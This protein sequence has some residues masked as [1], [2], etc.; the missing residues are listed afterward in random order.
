MIQN[1]NRDVPITDSR[2]IGQERIIGWIESVTKAI[3][4]LTP[5]DGAGSPEGVIKAAQKSYY[6]DTVAQELYF[7]TTD[8][9]LNTGW[10]LLT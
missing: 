7:K 6:F 3:N 5:I 2:G 10:I 1:P 8:S 4:L 9:T